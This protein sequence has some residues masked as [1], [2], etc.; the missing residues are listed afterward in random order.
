[1]N[2]ADIIWS[3]DNPSCMIVSIRDKRT[4]QCLL[5]IS[6]A[7][8]IESCSR[9]QVLNHVSHCDNTPWLERWQNEKHGA[10]VSLLKADFP[11]N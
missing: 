1:M 11:T 4:N 2:A 3:I 10:I 6:V 9:E 8:I 7:E 5:R